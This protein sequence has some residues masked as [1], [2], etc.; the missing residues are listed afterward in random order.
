MEAQN[1]TVGVR[2]SCSVNALWKYGCKSGI[3]A[4]SGP[5]SGLR[6]GLPFFTQSQNY[7]EACWRFTT[8]AKIHVKEKRKEKPSTLPCSKN[9]GITSVCRYLATVWAGNFLEASWWKAQSYSCELISCVILSCS[10]DVELVFLPALH[11][12][13]SSSSGY[14]DTHKPQNSARHLA[15]LIPGFWKWVYSVSAL[16]AN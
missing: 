8:I 15:E 12:L 13:S 14:G 2:F 7:C 16:S 1:T 3:F 10:R 9:L 5:Y 4:N 6:K 11:H